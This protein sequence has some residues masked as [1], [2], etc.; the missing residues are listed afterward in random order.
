MRSLGLLTLALAAALAATPARAES[1]VAPP[2]VWLG[3][4]FQGD[5]GIAHVTEVHPGTG[6]AAAGILPD[7][8]IIA[9]NG[10]PLSAAPNGLPE[11][12]S[13][14]HIGQRIVVTLLRQGR[15]GL[16][17]LR[18]T[19][20]LTAKPSTDEMVYQ[21]L[22]DRAL[23]A[24]ALHDRHGAPVPASEWARRPQVWMVFDAG[25]DPCAAA[26]TTLRAHMMASDD[27]AAATPLRVVVLG[28]K[29]ELDAYLARVPLLGTI[30]RADRGEE[31]RL[32]IVRYFL[33]GLDIKNDGVLLVVDH[34]GVVRFATAVSA[35]EP[36]HAGACAAA[37]RATRA[38]R[39]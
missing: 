5:A 14:H 2:T 15:D 28:P 33:S 36:A 32:G 12:V 21:R 26:A 30:W 11:L 31:S 9:I 37:A 34:R 3:I 18:V 8:E 16:R 35:G 22:I 27:E 19:P 29:V 7:D 6:A 24:L 38:W 1:P 23:P 4:G 25:C 10:I 20:R 13:A 17:P 39:P